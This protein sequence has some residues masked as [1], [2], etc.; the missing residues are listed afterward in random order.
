MR[1]DPRVR[2]LRHEDH[3]DKEQDVSFREKARRR[4]EE[5]AQSAEPA[6]DP[7]APTAQEPEA[8]SGSA[9]PGYAGEL[10][11]LAKLKDAGIL[12]EEEFAAKKKQILGL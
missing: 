12:T 1:A 4:L 8:E 2:S 5:R 11:E 6:D 7:G 3:E 10:E 9:E